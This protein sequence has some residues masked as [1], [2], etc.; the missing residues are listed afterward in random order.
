MSYVVIPSTYKN[1]V[2]VGF[3]DPQGEWVDAPASE[4]YGRADQ[5]GYED[6]A[7]AAEY[8]HWLNGGN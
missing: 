3:Y 6:P 2:R 4:A 1:W 8:V 7:R 5:D